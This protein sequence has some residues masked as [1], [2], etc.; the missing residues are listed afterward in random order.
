MCIA[1][2]S[3][4][5]E[6]I[7]SRVW[8]RS[9]LPFYIRLCRVAF[10]C[11]SFKSERRGHSVGRVRFTGRRTLSYSSSSN[12][13]WDLR[14]LFLSR[15]TRLASRDSLHPES[16]HY[17]HYHTLTDYIWRSTPKKARRGKTESLLQLCCDTTKSII[18]EQLHKFYVHT[19]R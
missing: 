18:R 1:L 7:I 9:H 2:H 19:K 13:S 10:I 12:R 14:F 5:E 15:P 4:E 8:I 3:K 17:M 11:A 16:Q 6:D